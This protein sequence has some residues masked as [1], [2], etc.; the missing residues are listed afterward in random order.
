[1]RSDFGGDP[2][3]I[4][5]WD[6][7]AAHRVGLLHRL[8]LGTGALVAAESRSEPQPVNATPAAAARATS[9]RADPA[10]CEFGY[11]SQTLLPPSGRFPS[12][13]PC[14]RSQPGSTPFASQITPVLTNE[15]LTN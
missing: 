15:N 4:D 8:F 5:H 3:P 6:Q 12:L 1:M 9:R 11:G 10:A 14:L 13:P 2:N 7:C